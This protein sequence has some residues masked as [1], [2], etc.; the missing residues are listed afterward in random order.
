MDWEWINNIKIDFD[1]HNHWVWRPRSLNTS[2]TSVVYD[3]L[4]SCDLH[5]WPGWGHIW[6]LCV[7]PRTKTFIW[8]LAYGRL[9]TGAYLYDLNIGPSTTCSFCGL[10]LATA[11]HLL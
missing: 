3:H 11:S 9:P 10:E 6:I 2:T 4:V 1:A 5:P 7:L 8:K